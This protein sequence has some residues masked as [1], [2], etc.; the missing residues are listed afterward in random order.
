MPFRKVIGSIRHTIRRV[1]LEATLGDL[2]HVARQHRGLPMVVGFLSAP[3]GIGA[4]GALL[5]SGLKASGFSPS[6]FDLTPVLQK[7]RSFL[8]W[9]PE[10]EPADD[11]CGPVIVH[12]NGPGSPFALSA[13]G[14]KRLLGRFLVAFWA[15]ELPVIP[16]AWVSAGR[17]YQEI[18]VPSEFTAQALRPSFGDKVKV[19]G[20]PLQPAYV[21]GLEASTFRKRFF[22]GQEAGFLALAVADA[23]SSMSRKNPVGAIAAFQAA[24]H[25]RADVRLVVK[26]TNLSSAP[27]VVRQKFAAAVDGDARVIVLDGPLRQAEFDRLFAVADVFISLHRSEGFGLSI[28]R[29]LLAGTPTVVTNWSGNTDFADLPGTHPVGYTLVPPQSDKAEYNRADTVW[30]EPDLAMA[31]TVLAGL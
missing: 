26:T 17:H 11:G 13:L 28:A 20:Y 29:S 1:Y 15:W 8:P 6:S 21:R 5:Y 7:E 24:F 2:G 10:V 18:W 31:A 4:G 30:A 19:V 12:V 27:L 23:K 16:P 3:M 9:P 14:R 25:N 22:S